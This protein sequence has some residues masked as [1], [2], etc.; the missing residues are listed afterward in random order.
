MC[1]KS[2]ATRLEAVAVE[3]KDVNASLDALA[4]GSDR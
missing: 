3:L 4:D 2:N 1:R